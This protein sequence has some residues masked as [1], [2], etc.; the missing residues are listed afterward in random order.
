MA[1]LFEGGGGVSN[2]VLCEAKNLFAGPLNSEL[3]LGQGGSKPGQEQMRP[4][5]Q[6]VDERT[7]KRVDGREMV[8]G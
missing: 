6:Q 7:S 2:V 1:R 5:S 4:V 3:D 8:P